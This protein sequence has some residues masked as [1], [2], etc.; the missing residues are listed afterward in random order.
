MNLLKKSL[1]VLAVAAMAVSLAGCGG[2]SSSSKS[3]ESGEKVFRFGQS[4]PKV[5]LD[6]SGASSGADNVLEGL[7]RWNDDNKEEC[8]LAKDM[9]EVS[10]D[11]LTYTITLKK[12][13]KFSDGSDLTTEDVKYT[14]ERMFTQQ[15]DVQIHICTT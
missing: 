6:N 12:G 10:D 7:Y 15:Q 1:S 4:N 14:F 9:P 5:G 3:T 11:G 13:V 8:V 2:S